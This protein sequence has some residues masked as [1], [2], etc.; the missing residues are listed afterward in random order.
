ME[1][2]KPTADGTYLWRGTVDVIVGGRVDTNPNRRN[3]NVSSREPI[4]PAPGP[5]FAPTGNRGRLRRRSWSGG[6]GGASCDKITP[7]P[8]L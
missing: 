3:G 2:W 6:S 8:G 7:A 1:M 4:P 5:S